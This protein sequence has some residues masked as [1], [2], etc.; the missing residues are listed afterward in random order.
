MTA[1]DTDID[2]G[3]VPQIELADTEPLLPPR[4]G[5]TPPIKWVGGKRWLV[6]TVA[7]SIYE[8]L[9][10]TQGRYIEPFMGS[11]AI[12]LDLGLPG[13]ILGDVCKPLVATYT[14]IR[15]SPEAVA[16]ALKTLVEKGTDKES[17][18]TVRA[19]EPTS[20]VFAAAR[21]IYLNK[22]GFNG[23]YRENKSGKFN[24]PHGGDRSNAG[25]P[26]LDDLHAVA[27][28]LKDAEIRVA[29]FRSTILRATAGDVIYVDSPYYETFSDYTAGGFTDEDH[30]DLALALKEAHERGAVFIASNSDH[31]HVRELYAWATVVPVHE[32]H[33]VGATAERRGMKAAVL[34][35]S[36]DTIL[37]GA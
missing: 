24:V 34:I 6:P 31:E 32:R 8:R 25:I 28:A 29:D 17:Y 5:C 33:A 1:I 2:T 36:D 21:F 9:A 4:A 20:V 26:G 10:A 15:K 23:L 27:K 35:M 13:M 19:S 14:T 37:R 18:L 16:W 30:L 11:G 7:P 12:A 22:F 3:P